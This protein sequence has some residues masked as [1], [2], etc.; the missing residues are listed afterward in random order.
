GPDFF[1]AKV[2]V[3]NTMWA[4][5]VEIHLRSSDWFRHGHDTDPAYDNVVLHVVQTVDCEVTTSSGKRIPQLQLDIPAGLH[6]RYAELQRTDNYPR[7]YR[8]IPKMD[9]FT[10]HSW[11]DTLLCERMEERAQQVKERL[12]RVDGDWE[13]ALFTTIARNF[14]FGLNGD[15]FEAWARRIPFNRIGKH[16]DEVFQI[17]AIFLGQ[18]GLLEEGT[19]PPNMPPAEWQLL[20]HEFRYQQTLFSLP[21]PLSSRQWRYLRTRP[22]NFPHIRLFQLAQLYHEGR[23]GL[24]ALLDAIKEEQPLEALIRLLDVHAHGTTLSRNS[25]QLI[26]INSVVPVLYAHAEM[27]DNWPLRQRLADILQ[28][29]PAEDNHILRQWRECGLQADSAADSQAL[30]QLKRAYCDRNDCLRCKFGYE[31]LKEQS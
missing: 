15:V 2:R 11:M 17:E 1:N 5:N 3:G 4:G 22:Q 26:V 28:S 14:G 18:G 24:S 23:V 10:V 20:Q 9:V 29:I 25:C 16:R 8:I 21:E 7:C 6:Q 30:I 27:H 19:L 31:Y 12:Q 13:W